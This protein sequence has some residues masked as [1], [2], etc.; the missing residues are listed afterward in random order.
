M[1]AP[2]NDTRQTW[3]RAGS[4]PAVGMDSKTRMRVLALGLP[5]GVGLLAG[6]LTISNRRVAFVEGPLPVFLIALGV[7]TGILALA[8]VMILQGGNQT[9]TTASAPLRSGVT[10]RMQ[11]LER[12]DG[13]ITARLDAVGARL[14][15]IDDPGT[16]EA[17][18]EMRKLERFMVDVQGVA[19]L[20]D[21]D[22]ELEE[23]DAAALIAAV[24]KS[25]ARVAGDRIIK[26]DLPTPDV[27]PFRADRKLMTVA[28]VNLV[29]N[30]VKFSTPHTP[31][32]VRVSDQAERVMFEVIDEGPGIPAGEDVWVELVRGSNA[33]DAPGTGLGLPLVRLVA[34]RHGGSAELSS[35]RTGT[36]ARLVI[37]R[38]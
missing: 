15:T 33:G 16:D 28:L 2:S 10:E 3:S 35:T 5:V 17:R 27:A 36:V 34:E 30:S 14:D 23:I 38:P 13:V 11:M 18:A 7:V 24:L 25:S 6:L 21:V 31:I 8:A 19:A 32:V 26:A 22:L 12:L 20:H 1:R 29:I 9:P 4:V 37:P